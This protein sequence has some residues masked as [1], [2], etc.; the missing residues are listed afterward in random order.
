MYLFYYFY[1]FNC[2]LRG[3]ICYLGEDVEVFTELSLNTTL[4]CG[5]STRPFPDDATYIFWHR[6]NDSRNSDV[7]LVQKLS[8][9]WT[10][11]YNDFSS[12]K[13]KSTPSRK[14][15]IIDVTFDDQ[16][17]YSCEALGSAQDY[18]FNVSLTIIGKHFRSI[19]QTKIFDSIGSNWYCFNCKL[20][21]LHSVGYVRLAATK[22]H[23]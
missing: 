20:C 12:D 4:T 15:T 18:I 23:S 3:S 6:Y 21:L 19:F 2:L 1:A 22:H 10:N 11:Y 14:L 16:R 8:F 5:S 7:I 9:D 17:L 13:Y